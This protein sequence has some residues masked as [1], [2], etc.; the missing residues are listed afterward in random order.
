MNDWEL[1]ID[2]AFENIDTSKELYKKNRFG[3]AA[4]H[5][6]QAL[7]ISIKSYCYKFEIIPENANKKS[8]K[9]HLPSSILFQEFFD[10]LLKSYNENRRKNNYSKIEGDIDQT[11]F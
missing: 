3:L 8:F 10:Y 1:C 7:E 6:Q 11:I 9:T 2:K 4:F 5:A